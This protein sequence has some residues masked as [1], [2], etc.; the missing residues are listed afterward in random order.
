MQAPVTPIVPRS[1][2][3]DRIR[4]LQ[5]RLARKGLDA[6][7]ILQNADLFYFC[8]TIQQAHL[9]VPVEG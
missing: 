9:W 8:G 2:I 7:L 4:A 3:I 6:A 5:T 1:E